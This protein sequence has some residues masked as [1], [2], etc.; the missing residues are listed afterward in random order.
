MN[1]AKIY[2][3]LWSS[4][5]NFCNDVLEGKD[6]SYV[7]WE[8]HANLQ[9][10]PD[11]DLIGTTALTF[12]EEEPELFTGSFAIGVSTQTSDVGLFRLRSYVGEV[13]S[14][15]RPGMKIALYDA[16]SVTQLGWL[17]VVD[18]THVMPMQRA[19]VRPL[20]FIQCNFVFDATTVLQP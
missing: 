12:T 19:D 16:A 4:L 8:S 15:M 17:H 20:Q 5:V 7:D 2:E 1:A 10:L 9:E 11:G 14:K 6:A 3:N 18:G 13:F